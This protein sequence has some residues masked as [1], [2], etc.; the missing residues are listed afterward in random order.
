M[1]N[2][3]YNLYFKDFPFESE[4]AIVKVSDDYS[5]ITQQ[6]CYINFKNEYKKYTGFY[7]YDYAN[8]F[9]PKEKERLLNKH[10]D[11][12][13]KIERTTKHFAFI[14]VLKDRENPDLEGKILPF[15]FGERIKKINENQENKIHNNIFVLKIKMTMG[16]QN[17]DDCYYSDEKYSVTDYSLNLNITKRPYIDLEKLDRTFKLQK[18]RELIK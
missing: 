14:Q 1:N 3:P 17:F 15:Q 4:I 10:R 18:I 12:I 7:Q 11:F 8:I 6:L 5:W 16:F 9:I 2:L 13:D